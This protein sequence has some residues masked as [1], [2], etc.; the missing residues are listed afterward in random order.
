MRQAIIASILTGLAVSVLFI[1][2][3]FAKGP[4]YTLFGLPVGGGPGLFGV[5]ASSL[6]LYLISMMTSDTGKNPEEFLAQAHR[7]DI[8]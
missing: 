7:P 3:L 4:G 5:V 8:D 1:V 6:V 2:L